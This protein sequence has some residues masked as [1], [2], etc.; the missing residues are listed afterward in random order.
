[1]HHANLRGLRAM[2]RAHRH[3]MSPHLVAFLDRG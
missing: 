2:A 3:E 1:M